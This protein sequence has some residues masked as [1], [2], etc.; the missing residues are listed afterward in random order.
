MA[1][2]CKKCP[3]IV[4][5]Q[6]GDK[7]PPWCPRC[8]A[9]LQTATPVVMGASA[10]GVTGLPAANIAVPTH[11][12]LY[13][14]GPELDLQTPAL[15]SL[16]REET[17]GTS[18][19]VFRGKLLWQLV[20]GGCAIVCFGIV[21][22]AVSQLIHPRKPPEVGVYGVLG[23][24]TIGG[25]VAV[26]VAYRL[27]GQKYAV[28]PDQL[29]EW[30]C[31]KPTSFGWNQ[32]RE[33][34]QQAHPAWTNYRVVTRLGRTFT[35]KGEIKNH[36]RLGELIAG[37]VAALMLPAALHELESG[38]DVRIGPLLVNRAGVVVDG[39]L[40]PW[41]RI[42]VLAFGLNPNPKKGTSMVSNMIHLRIGSSW[43]ELGDIPNYRL[44]E[45][46]AHRLFPACVSSV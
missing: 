41:H 8:G 16:L 17:L 39:Q 14:S 44:F 33:V 37:R 35:V 15:P 1:L 9:D 2:E 43:V 30:Q 21:A 10:T 13:E 11:G 12:A 23:M 7:A 29:V 27:C 4:T 25:L 38:R 3:F 36:K 5:V 31:F 26:Y 19:E 40:E 18:E 32:I 22:I 28:F 34:F 6:P 42:G 24:F 45:E 20:A 46:L